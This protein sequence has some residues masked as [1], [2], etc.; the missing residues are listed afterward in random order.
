MSQLPD[1]VDRPI[2]SRPTCQ[3]VQELLGAEHDGEAV[4]DPLSA[5]HARVCEA[6]GELRSALRELSDAFAPLRGPIAPS[7]DLWTAIEERAR[8]GRTR[9]ARPR[10]ALSSLGA[11]LLGAAAVLALFVALDARRAP[12]AVPASPGLTRPFEL[13]SEQA[14]GGTRRLTSAPEIRLAHSLSSREDHR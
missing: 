7:A 3:R 8:R 13:L 1:S 5:E 4:L 11:S 9:A 10:H 2:D 14:S 12:N 6:C